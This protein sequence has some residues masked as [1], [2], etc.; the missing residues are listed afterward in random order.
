MKKASG[1]SEVYSEPSETSKI[2]LSAK[3]VDC[4]QPL[5]IFAKNF[6]LGISQAYEY[7]SDKTK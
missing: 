7:A 5:T 6:I 3:I 1:Y 4:I 2:E